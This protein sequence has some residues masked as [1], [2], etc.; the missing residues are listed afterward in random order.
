MQKWRPY[1]QVVAFVLALAAAQGLIV[2]VYR[3]VGNRRG[4]TKE[5]AF[6]YERLSRKPA[7]DLLLLRPDGSSWRLADLRGKPVLLHFW[8]T[9]C[10]PCKEELPGLLELGHDLGRGGRFEVIAVTL[11]KDWAKVRSFF[12]GEIPS[13]VLQDPSGHAT[14]TYDVSTLP[15]TYLVAPDGTLLFR[16][17]GARDWRTGAAR[18]LLERQIHGR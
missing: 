11:D 10:P 7:P 16:F 12:G 15:D 6:R 9:W 18:D 4:E 3:W 8:A 14:R 17:G 1:F 2:L 13:Q 5:P